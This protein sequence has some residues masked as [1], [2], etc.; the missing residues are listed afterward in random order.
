VPDTREAAN[1][2]VV[3]ALVHGNQG[4]RSGET[5]VVSLDAFAIVRHV[6]PEDEGQ[7]NQEPIKDLVDEVHAAVRDEIEEKQEV[8]EEITARVLEEEK[9]RVIACERFHHV[10]LEYDHVED[11]ADAPPKEI[12]E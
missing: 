5:T 7:D 6:H 11:E 9:V 2:R 4:H 1:D 8:D 12:F 3:A 10:A